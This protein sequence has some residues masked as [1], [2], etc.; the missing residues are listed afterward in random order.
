MTGT[1]DQPT[2]AGA[3]AER[4]RRLFRFFGATQAR[5]RSPVYEALSEGVARDDGLLAL[6]LDTPETQRRPAL[7][8]AAVN[9]LL[10]S[11][12]D[13]ELAAYYPIHGGRRGVDDRLVPAFSAFCAPHRGELTRLLARRSTQTNEI[14]RCVA[15]RLGVEH[16]QRHWP[17][18]VALVEVGASAGLNLLFDRYDYRLDGTAREVPPGA[19][20]SPVVVSTDVRGASGAELL[21]APPTITRRLGVDRHPV[22]LSDP[23]ARAWLEAF[24]WPEQT[25]ELA[26]L[27]GAVAL[28]RTVGNAPVVT[29]DAVTDTA[30]T[31]AG[32]PGGEPVVVFTASL[33]SYLTAEARTAFVAQLEEAARARPVAWVFAEGPGLLATTPLDLPA[34]RGPLARRNSLYAVG[35]ALRGAGPNHDRLLG[36]ADPYLRWISPARGEADDFEWVPAG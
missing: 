21:G 28:A 36:L 18:P 35:T 5:G 32:L 15:L 9:L 30:R 29:G 22:D 17:G 7:L 10:A 16:V 27:R 8:F 24:V 33:L 23:D 4:L 6:L 13:T 11:R 34:L 20:A 2:G 31:L 26:T 1:R 25:A 3:G 14:R 12:R 19:H